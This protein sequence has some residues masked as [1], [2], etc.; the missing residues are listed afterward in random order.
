MND[1]PPHLGKN[2]QSWVNL[3]MEYA[4]SQMSSAMVQQKLRTGVFVIDPDKDQ[5][6]PFD[7]ELF[8]AMLGHGNMTLVVPMEGE[9]L[10]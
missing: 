7:R 2:G 9:S 6:I 4:W 5:H 10:Y 8:V 1:A 3:S